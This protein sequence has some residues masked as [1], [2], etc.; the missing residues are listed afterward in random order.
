[1]LSIQRLGKVKGIAV[2]HAKCGAVACKSILLMR[3]I[4]R[5]EKDKSKRDLSQAY[6]KKGK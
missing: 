3:K 5:R 4:R 2:L 6:G 1:M